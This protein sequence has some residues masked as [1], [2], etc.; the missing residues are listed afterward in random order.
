M[1]KDSLTEKTESCPALCEGRECYVTGNDC[2]RKVFRECPDYTE[3]VL[4][5]GDE[6]YR[7]TIQ[8]ITSRKIE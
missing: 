2:K 6:L 3:S 4:P 7:A 8:A 1:A 5:R